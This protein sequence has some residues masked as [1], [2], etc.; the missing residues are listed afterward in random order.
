MF[1]T[2]G[3]L[4]GVRLGLPTHEVFVALG[5]L[6]AAVVFV[7]EARRRGHTD[8]RLLWVVVGALVG[9][10]VMMRM[11]TWLQHVRPARQRGARGA[12]ALRQPVGPRRPGRRVAR[13]AR[14]QAPR[15]LPA[16]HR[17]PVR[18]RRGPRDGGRAGRLPAHRAAR[19]PHRAR[20][21]A[22]PWMPR[23]PRGSAPPPGCRCTRRSRTRSPSSSRPSPRCGSGCA[24]GA[25][26]PADLRPL[27][28]GLR[29]LPLPRRVRARQRGRVARP[30]PAAAVPRRD[31]PA[32]PGPRR[33]AAPA[34]A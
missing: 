26:R 14:R 29:R 12:V 22:S 7:L 5:V 18:P 32:R 2:V 8:E 30:H 27:R 9:G 33:R 1:P 4:L 34:T 16:A 19:N 21:T 11:G 15:R 24:A 31:R 25:S 10:G 13:R 28:R 20:R 17:R 3:D 6:A 23:R